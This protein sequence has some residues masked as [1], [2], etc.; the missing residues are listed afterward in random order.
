MNIEEF[1]KAHQYTIAALGVLGTFSAVL[2]ALFSSIAAMRTSRTRISARASINVIHHSSLEGKERPKYLVVS[3]RNLGA[4][5]VHIP[6][7]FFHWKLPL[8][9]GVYEVLPLDYS[10][11]DEWIAQ[12][13]YPVEIRARGSEIFFLSPISVF[14]EDALKT[15]IG[16]SVWSRF[17]YRFLSAMVFTDEG[18]TFNVKLESSLR[19][20]MV[21]LCDHRSNST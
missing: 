3:I 7:G 20:E 6:M 18:R 4:M 17:R 11:A 14:Q 8:Q 5:P 15:F 10:A 12:K 1:L 19:K 16:T 2:V 21:R 13:R 9:R